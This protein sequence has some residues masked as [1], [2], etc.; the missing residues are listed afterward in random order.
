LSTAT[1]ANFTIDDGA[2]PVK[3]ISFTGSDINNQYILLKWSTSSEI[4]SKYFDVQKSND[5]ISFTTF[6]RVNAAGSTTLVQNYSA[7]DYHPQNGYNFYRL[8]MVDIDGTVTYSKIIAVNFG[9]QTL[10]QVFPNPASSYFTVTAGQEAMKEIS[11]IDVSGK[12][13]QR[14]VNSNGSSAVTVNSESFAG[15]VYIIKITTAAHLYEQ[16]LF[17]Q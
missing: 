3:L 8:R 12:T 2:L 7:N 5:G 4:D 10:P 14:I 11:V 6:A 1:F 15:G 9:D 16:K 17:K 13:I